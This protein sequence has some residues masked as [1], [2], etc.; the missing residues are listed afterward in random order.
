MAA[1]GLKTSA[2]VHPWCDASVLPPTLGVLEVEAA[3]SIAPAIVLC[4]VERN[5]SPIVRPENARAERGS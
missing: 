3:F 5:V 1:A 2:D 4:G